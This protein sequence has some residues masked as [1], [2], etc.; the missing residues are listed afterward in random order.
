MKS[1]ALALIVAAASMHCGLSAADSG[2][3]RESFFVGG[4]YVGAGATQVMQGQMFVE[5]LTPTHVTHPYPLV[6]IHGGAQ[7]AMNWMTTPDRRGGWAQWF[8]D[9]GWKVYMVDQA[10]RGRSAWQPKVN[11]ELVAAPVS[12]V[13]RN[14]T[15]PE[16][17]N[18]WPQAKLHTQW[19]G[20]PHAGRAGH[21]VFDQFYA[22][23]VPSLARNEGEVLMQKAGA[24]L[25]DQIGAAVLVVH[26]QAGLYG[27]LIADA[28]P[29]LVKGIVALEP[30]GPPF[31][32]PTTQG[33]VPDRPY[34]LTSTPLT[35]EPAVTPDAPLQ[36]KTQ[37]HADGPDLI[38]CQEQQGAP[39]RLTRLA[40]I[41]VLIATT[42]ASYHAMYD[43]CTS[44]FLTAAGVANDFVRLADV[45]L[46]GNGHMLML[47]M[48]NELIAAWLDQWMTRKIF[49]S[50]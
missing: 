42:E 24:A 16:D 32:N 22:S 6:L 47:E 14:F 19:P 7:T 43:H 13:E 50:K 36:F 28:R 37:D 2:V 4:E 23:Q 30:S 35:Y 1:K 5:S 46:K 26:S 33:A 15:A 25:L 44:R 3:R 8:A 29:A 41:P 20:G 21:P 40:G 31:M 38:P 34:G 17:F 18:A 45:G 48:N 27:W 10:A 39:R 11:G 49:P 9:N 12:V